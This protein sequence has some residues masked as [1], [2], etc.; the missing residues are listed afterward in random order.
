FTMLCVV[1]VRYQLYNF[2]FCWAMF[3]IVMLSVRQLYV[4]MNN[5]RL[6]RELLKVNLKVTRQAQMDFLTKL[7]NRRHIDEILV[8]YDQN[9]E[10]QVLGLL[11]IDVDLFKSINDTYGHDFGDKVLTRV[12]KVIRRAIRETDIGGRFGGDEFIAIL[13]GADGKAVQRVGERIIEQVHNDLL[14]SEHKVSL[15]L[16]GASLEAAGQ[17]NILLN[18]ADKAL[19]QAKESGRGKLV[20]ANGS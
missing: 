20:L 7:A 12:A 9:E 16:G 19:Y 4:L 10:E 15:S 17:V 5:K 8:Q 2:V 1:F 14:L 3:L 13:P 18:L 6:Y 11:F